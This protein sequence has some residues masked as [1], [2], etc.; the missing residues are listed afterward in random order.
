MIRRSCYSHRW[1]GVLLLLL[2]TNCTAEFSPEGQSGQRALTLRV[3]TYNIED[4]RTDDLLSK[5]HPRLRAI[6]AVIQRNRP[7]IV[8]LNE[9]A[10]DQ[11]GVPG[12]I[13]GD[14]WGLNARRFVEKYL[15]VAQE[16]DLEPL[17]YHT[18][19]APSNTGISSGFDFDNNGTAVHS[20]PVPPPA[21][22]DGSPGPQT[23]EGQLYGNDAWGFGTFPGQ[24]AMG[25]LVRKDLEILTDSVRTF[26]LLRWSDVPDA[27]M[28]VRPVTQEHWYSNEAW[29]AFRLSSKS[30]WDV[31]IRLP[32]NTILHIL[33]SQPPAFDGPEYRNVNRNHNE[34]RFWADYLN[35]ADYVVDDAG[36]AGGLPQADMF[37]LLGDLNADIDEGDSVNNPVDHFLLSHPRVK[38]AFVPEA[39]ISST[40]IFPDLSL[41]DTATWG[42]RIDYVLPSNQITIR[43]GGIIRPTP[44]E[45]NQVRPS[46]HFLVWLDLVFGPVNVLP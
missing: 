5:E 14:V 37:I 28:P 23:P 31:P 46:D 1:L 43:N 30:H 17:T 4:V 22:A 33:A 18:F 29:N 32:N 42:L 44:G 16:P 36:Q 40:A 12:Y 21:E 8:L 15:S 10:Y 27:R 41:D 19:M 3:A 45:S 9:L 35:G 38:G 39:D 2:Y 6:A 20:Y 13:D 25:L 24:Y 7:D 11:S 34:I 26:R